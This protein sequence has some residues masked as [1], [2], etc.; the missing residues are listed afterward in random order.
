MIEKAGTGISGF[1][2]LTRGGLPRGRVTLLAGSAG[3]GKTVMALQS[4]VHAAGELGEP[5]VF[6][7]FEEHSGR[8][9]VN[10][11]SFNW[12]L[13][14]QPDNQMT[15]MDCQPSV[16]LVQSGS[17]DLDGLLAGLGAVI[18]RIG[19]RRIVLDALDTLLILL[20]TVH[21]VRREV[22]R[23]HGWLLERDLTAIITAK[24]HVRGHDAADDH[25]DFMQFMV[26]SV[27]LLRHEVVQGVSQRSLRVLKYRGSSFDENDVPYVIGEQGLERVI[28]Q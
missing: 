6:V 26:D 9:K 15:F 18:D 16:D 2:E 13:D 1:D 14:K 24:K 8:I 25:M 23:L 21:D 11:A 5:S 28:R 22:Y 3:S 7:A 17:F 20:P 12:Q 4:L 27:V 19:A 10:A